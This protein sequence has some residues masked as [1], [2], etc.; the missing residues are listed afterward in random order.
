[1]SRRHSSQIGIDLHDTEI[2]AVEVRHNGSRSQIVRASHV[3]TPANAISRGTIVEPG[4]VGFAVRR[5]LESMGADLSLPVVFSVSGAQT[6]ARPVTLPPSPLPEVPKLLAGEVEYQQLLKSG[7]QYGYVVL[8]SSGADADDL[9]VIVLG[10]ESEAIVALQEVAKVAELKIAAVE[11]APLPG[12]RAAST[13]LSS[14]PCALTLSVRETS[15]D[16]LLS[17]DGELAF[18]RRIDVGSCDL[19]DEFDSG[20]R[21]G[22][23]RQA[24]LAPVLSPAFDSLLAEVQRTVG[25]LARDYAAVAHVD[26]LRLVLDHPALAGMPAALAERLGTTVEVVVPDTFED[27][28][29]DL[30]FRYSWAAGLARFGDANL[31]NATPEIDLYV[32]E[33]QASRLEET[34]RNLRGS[35]AV[36][37]MAILLGGIGWGL[38]ARQIS[39]TRAEGNALAQR[40]ASIRGETIGTLQ[41]QAEEERRY[42]LLAK[43][44]VPLVHLTDEL[45]RYLAPGVGLTTLT[46]S[47][48]DRIVLSGEATSEAAM[49]QTFEGLK[50]SPLL[51]D[52]SVRSFNRK[53]ELIAGGLTFEF[54]GTAA[55]LDRISDA[56]PT[57]EVAQR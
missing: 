33:R 42:E 19:A 51:S 8:K 43:E 23:S 56:K 5:L 52:L 48:G 38:M 54:G 55:T 18:V 11:P 15:S 3:P 22:S 16:L 47:S 49:L 53:D 21:A 9:S 27:S 29:D 31:P 26:R 45:A 36:A 28:Q 46:V 6:V 17:L 44:G 7:S 24:R 40:A 2:R 20:M 12:Y 41:A 35:L 10:V 13:A 4:V 37:A 34:V 1:M 57:V 50:A 39:T 25:Y 30:A 14:A 32:E